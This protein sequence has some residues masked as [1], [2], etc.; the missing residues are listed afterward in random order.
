MKLPKLRAAPLIALMVISAAAFAQQ[1]GPISITTSTTACAQITA[2]S[3]TATIGIQ[4]TGTWTGTLQPEVAIQGQAAA[5]VQVT[6][7]TSTTPQGTITANGVYTASVA[8][9]SVFLLCGPTG[10]GTAVIF[11][12]G[13]KAARTSA[14]GGGGTVTSVSGSAPIVSSGG[15]TPAISCATCTTSAASLTSN[16]L[17]KGSGSQAMAASAVAT[18]DGTTLTYT[19]TGGVLSNNAGGLKAGANGGSAGVL[20]LLGSTSGDATCTAPAVAGTTSNSVTCTNDFA[21]PGV[22]FVNPVAKPSGSPTGIFNEASQN[23]VFYSN[24][25]AWMTGNQNAIFATKQFSP[26]GGNKI[27][28]TAN[29]TTAAN[30]NLQTI[31]GLQFI[32]TASNAINW[33]FHCNLAYSQ[34]TATAAVAFGIQAATNSPT[35]IFATGQ[36]WTSTT[37]ATN[38][39]L[40]TLAT[41]TA[42]NIVSATPSATATNFNVYLDG[43]LELAASANTINFMVS[44][45][46]SGDAVTV[47]RGSYCLVF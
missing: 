46:T 16:A 34:A 23:I 38:G 40:A 12:N 42:T 36:E 24:G 39:I 27:F 14:G 20:H 10:T 29:F 35:N 1:V 18:D 33:N 7:S 47:L 32:H 21:L 8:G 6:P 5:N 37:A 15:N 2:A 25:T 30:T 43:T 3:D 44:T 22:Q 28:V 9:S 13:S 19:G 17:L 45:A 4:V 41:T 26:G 31:T 11:M